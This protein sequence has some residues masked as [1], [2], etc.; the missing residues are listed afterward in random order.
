MNLEIYQTQ[1]VMNTVLQF[2]IIKYRKY[3]P[4]DIKIAILNFEGDLD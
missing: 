3:Q 1:K 2:S 4:S